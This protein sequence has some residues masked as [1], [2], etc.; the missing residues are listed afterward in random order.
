MATFSEYVEVEAE[1]DLSPNEIL[2]NCS[3]QE[4]QELADL[5]YESGYYPKSS[6]NNDESF[7]ANGTSYTEQ[8]LAKALAEIWRARNLLNQTQLARIHAIT[9]ESYV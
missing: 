1:L 2:D 5:L 9:R 3:D 6:P 4:C 8:E 7:F